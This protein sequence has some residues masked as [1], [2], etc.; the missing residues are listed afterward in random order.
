MRLLSGDRAMVPSRSPR[1]E[2]LQSVFAFAPLKLRRTRFALTVWRGLPS[3]SS[4]I[5]P[6]FALWASARQPSLASRAKGW[7]AE[8]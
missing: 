7:L 4:R 5:R 6:A 8:P 3:R 1:A 2:R